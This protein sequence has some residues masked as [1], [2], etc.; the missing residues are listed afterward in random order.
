MYVVRWYW[1]RDHD[2]AAVRNTVRKMTQRSEGNSK[3]KSS[4]YQK[5]QSKCTKSFTISDIY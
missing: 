2:I 4:E 5:Q 1:T 3:S